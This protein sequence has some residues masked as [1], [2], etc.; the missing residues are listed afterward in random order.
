MS[1]KISVVTGAKGY[2]G[3]TLVTKLVERGE[4]VRLALHSPTHDFDELGCEIVTGSIND[5]DYLCKAFEGADTVYHVAGLVDITGTKDDLVWQ[6]NYEGTKCVLEACKKSGVKKL[7][8]VSSVDCVPVTP[9]MDVI[10]EPGHFDPDNLSDAYGKSKAAATELVNSSGDENLKCCSVHPSC[11]IGP[12][13]FHHSSSV[14]SMITLYDHG[15]FPMSLNFGAYNF[16][17]V[18]DVADGM[19]AAAEKGRNG[20]SYFLSGECLSVDG[21]VQVLAKVNNKKPP[22]IKLGKKAVLAICPLG[23]WFFKVMKMPPVL[24]PFSIAKICENCNFS[25]AKA[26][27]DLGY[28]PMSAEKSLTDTVY[29]LKEHPKEEKANK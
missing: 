28:S 29:W 19:I 23:A 6:V 5:I 17:D 11:V 20:Q 2:L 22:R 12:N 27:A 1:E 4:K 8:Y 16:V 13:D 25:Y 15:L 3:H 7:V 14:C 21:F 26:A 10:T 24:T 18:R 9:D